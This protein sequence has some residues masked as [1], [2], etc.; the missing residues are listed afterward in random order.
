MQVNVE[1]VTPEI[2]DMVLDYLYTGSCIMTYGNLKQLVVAANRMSIT[3]LKTKCIDELQK[4]L[5]ANNCL[6][7]KKLAESSHISSLNELID[8]YATLNL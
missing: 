5:E 8:K 3:N 7:I 1:N 2:M 4:Y 6:E